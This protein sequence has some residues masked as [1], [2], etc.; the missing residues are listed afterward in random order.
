MKKID[1]TIGNPD[2]HAEAWAHAPG[3][4]SRRRVDENMG[5]MKDG[6]VS[7]LE[8]QILDAHFFDGN[9]A[10]LNHKTHV[11]LGAG[12]TQLLMG[13]MQFFKDKGGLRVPRPSWF[14][15]DDMA[16]MRNCEINT[17]T[18]RFVLATCPNNPDGAI[19]IAKHR[20]VVYDAVYNW[21]HYFYTDVSCPA[22]DLGQCVAAM[23]SLSKYT[24]HAGSRV[25]WMLTNDKEF[26]DYMRWYVE[27]DSSGVSVDGQLTAVE[28]MDQFLELGIKQTI[29]ENLQQRY[30]QVQE[31]SDRHKLVLH[32]KCG[33]FAWV[34]GEN[35]E[36][37][38]ASRGVSVIAGT[39]FSAAPT[40]CRLNLACDS[41]TWEAFL[42]AM[43]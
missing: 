33:M 31:V 15:I 12:A 20:G 7:G 32:S 27:Y 1:L 41:T 38:F 34:E 3:A 6:M 14:R 42:D 18:S 22:I 11:V 26:A 24:G 2:L 10:N 4:I 17:D 30:E 29:K 40:F 43:A 19:Q 13:V 39:R 28:A 23:F 21:D 8:G 36:E 37:F 25:G 5:Y 35:V 9:V 16:K